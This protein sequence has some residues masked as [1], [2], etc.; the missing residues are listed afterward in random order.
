MLKF[1]ECQTILCRLANKVTI[2]KIDSYDVLR[3]Q[4]KSFKDIIEILI[5][6]QRTFLA[7]MRNAVNVLRSHKKRMI[8]DLTDHI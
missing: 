6:K 3:G 7:K 1:I 5:D 4:R 8:I 2:L